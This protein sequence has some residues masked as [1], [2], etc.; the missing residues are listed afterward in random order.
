MKRAN[1]DAA[2]AAWRKG[3]ERNNETDFKTNNL[4]EKIAGAKYKVYETSN[5]PI[6]DVVQNLTNSERRRFIKGVEKIFKG[7]YTK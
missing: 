4:L 5:D 1:I 6:Y 2:M 7:G 3:I